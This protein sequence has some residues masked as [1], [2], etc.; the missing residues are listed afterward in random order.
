M[1]PQPA[2]LRVSRI[3]TQTLL[4]HKHSVLK[5]LGLAAEL[6]LPASM[7]TSLLKSS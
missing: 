1:I 4:N 6:I 3:A 7:K 2:M 5:Q